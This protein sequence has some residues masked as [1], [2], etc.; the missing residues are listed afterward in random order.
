MRPDAIRAMIP[1]ALTQ[2][3]LEAQ[4]GFDA[5]A[6]AI[7]AQ[8]VDTMF[9]LVG[10]ANVRIIERLIQRHDVRWIA[11]RHESAAV[12]MA[13]GYARATGR[14]GV[15]S[16]TQGA[17]LM[18][19]ASA[20]VEARTARSPVVLLAGDSARGAAPW[21]RAPVPPAPF[22]LATAG[23]FHGVDTIERLADDVRSAF[24]DASTRRG[25]VVL[26]VPLDVQHALPPPGWSPRP[27]RS[28]HVCPTAP[29]GN[30]LV[31]LAD[32]VR[33]AR[34]PVVLAGVGAVRSEAGEAI[35]ELAER[36][37]ALL[38]TTLRANGWFD[39]SPWA[40]G[41]AGNLDPTAR[42]VAARAD[43]LLS[44]GAGLNSFTLAHGR[45]FPEATVVQVDDD[46]TALGRHRG[47]ALEV[48]GDA[49]VTAEALCALLRERPSE[50]RHARTPEI[51]GAIADVRARLRSSG[52]THREAPLTPET[53]ARVCDA[54]LPA[55]RAVV[56]G[57]GNF[58]GHPA[59][60]V[61]VTDPRRLF[62]PWESGTAGLAVPLGLGVAVGLPATL[63][64]IFEGDGSMMFHLAEIESA[65]RNGISMLIVVIDDAAYSAETH[66][67]DEAGVDA[68]LSFYPR[69][70][71]AEIAHEMGARTWVADTADQLRA[72]VRE[73]RS[74]DGPRLVQARVDR[75]LFHAELLAAFDE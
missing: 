36:A 18:Q 22:A 55:D 58:C 9:G 11:T 3:V 37:G 40:L 12:A 41:I 56:V 65:A 73:A 64:V 19:T 49:R 10:E 63:A 46:P 71:L 57:I 44:F 47:V 14:I 32:M 61:A 68:E 54:E 23:A 28:P 33:D 29:D 20:L 48:L 31:K 17:G 52:E 34:M 45:V 39:D 4:D 21:A 60:R 53:I 75:R 7:A 50:E 69:V 72:A 25:P 26:S 62:L 2:R 35:R 27:W 13:D 16:V 15:C 51:R 1:A 38:V 42:Q 70:R 6:D 67:L 5:T 30:T 43:L 8:G 24:A 59:Q 66:V 74:V